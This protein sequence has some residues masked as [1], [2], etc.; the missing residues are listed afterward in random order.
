[1]EHDTLV[2]RFVKFLPNKRYNAQ[3]YLKDLYNFLQ[4][5]ALTIKIVMSNLMVLTQQLVGD[6]MVFK[7]K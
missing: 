7:L 6:T 3:I 1:M 4:T 2:E 5:M